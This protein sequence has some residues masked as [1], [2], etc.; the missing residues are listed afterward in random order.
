MPR[1]IRIYNIDNL[2]EHSCAV[3]DIL[4]DNLADYLE[5]NKNL[6]FPHKHSF[7][8]L[9]Y[10]T[11]GAGTHSIDFIH[12]PVQAGQLYTMIPGQV[13][14]WQFEGNPDGFIINFSESFLHAFLADARYLDKFSFFSGNTT[15]QVI[16]I[17]DAYR[18][19]LENICSTIVEETQSAAPNH[20]DYARVELI[21]LFVEIS[22][23]TQEHSLQGHNSYN[24]VLLKNFKKLIDIHYHEKRLT[25]DYAELLYITPNHLNALCKD[26]TGRAA[27]ELI[28][29]RVLLEAKRLLINAQLSIA[30]IAAALDFEDNSYFSKF[31]KKYENVTP[32]TFRKQIIN[33]T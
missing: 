18:N 29:D 8:H 16:D 21:K 33:N 10:F 26:A 27:G 13:H 17:P 7:Y 5:A 30:E 23:H 22:R 31:F 1:N 12:F 15:D 2:N 4:A 3:S 9:V 28:R 6:Q 20:L 25:K 32:E 19:R 14:S 24:N 11:Q